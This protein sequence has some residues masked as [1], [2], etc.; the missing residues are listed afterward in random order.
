LTCFN[1]VFKFRVNSG[2]LKMKEKLKENMKTAMKAK[3]KVRLETVR[4]ILSAIQYE[5]MQKGVEDLPPDAILAILQ[6][7]VKKRNEEL[8]Y[9][10]QA[11]RED[12]KEKLRQETAIIEE[13][14]PQQLSSEELEKVILE[15]LKSNPDF[16]MGL[17]MKSLKEKYAGQ[18][19][20]K[21][22]SELAKK[23]AK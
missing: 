20:G 3:D 16:N 9:A 23:H 14:L 6:R 12:L 22:A 4:S 18:Y 8:D 11:N 2:E 5:E 7:E 15:E 10:K 21:L 17:L 19:D 13:F 1:I